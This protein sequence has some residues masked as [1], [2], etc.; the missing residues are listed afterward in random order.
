MV[1]Y[2]PVP[3]SDEEQAVIL[4]NGGGTL[5][6]VKGNHIL[7]VWGTP[8]ERAYSI[9]YLCAQQIIDWINFVVIEHYC[10]NTAFYENAFIPFGKG[11]N[12]RAL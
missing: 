4:G 7:H 8:E 3:F 12:G 6:K 10:N 5:K 11:P 1:L 2:Q 9:G